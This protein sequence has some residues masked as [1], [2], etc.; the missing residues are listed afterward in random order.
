[1]CCVVLQMHPARWLSHALCFLPLQAWEIGG[2]CGCLAHV[3]GDTLLATLGIFF[4]KAFSWHHLVIF[5]GHQACLND[6]D[7]WRC[8]TRIR[9]PEEAAYHGWPTSAH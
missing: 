8:H 3:F 9:A 6:L 7:G 5:Q 4:F 2:R 1:M